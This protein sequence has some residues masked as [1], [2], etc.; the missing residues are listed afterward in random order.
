VI[1]LNV[2][3]VDVRDPHG[4]LSGRFE[5]RLDLKLWI[6]HSAAGCARSAEQVAGAAGLRRQEV[7]KNHGALLQFLLVIRQAVL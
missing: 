4:L 7:A 6:H 2:G 3:L 1:G 5:V